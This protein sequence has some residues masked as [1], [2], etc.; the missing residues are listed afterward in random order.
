M[1]TVSLTL[2]KTVA[3]SAIADS[4]TGGSTGYDFLESETGD[5]SPPEYALFVK[6]DGTTD[7]TNLAL[8]V[9][10]YAG[11]YGGDY[12]AAAD[13]TKLTAHGDTA[14]GYGLQVDFRWDGSPL[15]DTGQYTVF[16]TGV[17]I[18][19]VTRLTV[20]VASMSRN[21]AGTEVDAGTPVAGQIGATGDTVLGDRAHMTFRYV[22]PSGETATGRRQ[23]DI[24]LSFN[25]TS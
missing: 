18:S 19:Y 17:G 21:N 9:Q 25:F 12:S 2:M 5:A 10:A 13:L 24:Y 4:L 1:P 7:I 11:T 14:P 20:P 8:N 6:H 15:F 23:F 16:K 22:T 3:G